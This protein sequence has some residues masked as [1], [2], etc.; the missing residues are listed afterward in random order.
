MTE[1]RCVLCDAIIPEGVQ[2][3]PMCHAKAYAKLPDR[4]LQRDVPKPP[5]VY[6]MRMG[7]GYSCRQCGHGVSY[8]V[9]KYCSNC[10]QCQDWASVWLH[11][12][13]ILN[14]RERE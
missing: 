9:N 3:C 7:Y 8:A 12:K 11:E 5:K 13:E 10:G 14:G 6:K 2:Y 4:W 1:E